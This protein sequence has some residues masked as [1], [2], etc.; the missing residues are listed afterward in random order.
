MCE[1]KTKLS[2]TSWFQAEL[3]LTSIESGNCLRCPT[4]CRRHDLC[5]GLHTLHVADTIFAAEPTITL[6]CDWSPPRACH[7]SNRDRLQ[8][9]HGHTLLY[10]NVITPSCMFAQCLQKERLVELPAL[11][12]FG[13][14]NAASRTVR[15]RCLLPIS[16]WAQT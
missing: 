16:P 2:R 13:A 4:S 14:T 15:N 7:T 9:L 10:T 5:R 8:I 11:L 6:V 1:M 3:L 12:P